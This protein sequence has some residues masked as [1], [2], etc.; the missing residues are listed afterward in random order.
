MKTINTISYE[1]DDGAKFET[2][3]KCLAYELNHG[4]LG[5]IDKNCDLDYQD[6]Y[7]SAQN[8]SKYIHEN[9][10]AINSYVNKSYKV[11]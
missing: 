10:D 7:A 4:L 8:V 6:N 9:I 2:Y 11:S 3:K 1:A 5:H